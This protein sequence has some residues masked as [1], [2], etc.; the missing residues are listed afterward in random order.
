MIDRLDALHSLVDQ[1]QEKLSWAIKQLTDARL[2]A[3]EKQKAHVQKLASD[4]RQAIA[5][6]HISLEQGTSDSSVANQLESDARNALTYELEPCTTAEFCL[7]Q[8]DDTVRAIESVGY[9]CAKFCQMAIE[10]S[11]AEAH[12]WLGVRYQTGD[13]VNKNMHEAVRHFEIAAAA[14]SVDAQFSLA[15]RHLN[16][17]GV[18]Q[19]DAEGL[20]LLKLAAEKGH[21]DAQN[22]L[23]TRYI[24]GNGVAADS[25]TATSYFKKAANQGHRVAAYNLAT[26]YYNGDG[27]A[28]NYE[29]AASYYKQAADDGLPRAQVLLAEL[30]ESGEGVPQDIEQAMK[31][32]RMAADSGDPD[33]QNALAETLIQQGAQ[34][35]ASVWDE[36]TG[37][38]RTAIRYRYPQQIVIYRRYVLS[39]FKHL[40]S[41]ETTWTPWSENNKRAYF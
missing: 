8:P 29:Y 36:A 19:N 3:V 17:E 4:L 11:D 28:Q 18:P 23:A 6:A 39:I 1:K 16:G 34:S 37:Y 32:W 31:Y 33:A 10:K 27:V 5:A 35:N 13:S 12:Q 14:G 40:Y 20:R 30:Y 7:P 22:A 21:S 24:T 2:A 25:S 15:C 26:C 41:V 38:L 9:A